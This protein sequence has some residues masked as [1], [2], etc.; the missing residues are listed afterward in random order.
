M[1]DLVVMGIKIG[2]CQ[3][4][5]VD[6]DGNDVAIQAEAFKALPEVSQAPTADVISFHL[7]SGKYKVWNEDGKVIAEDLIFQ[8][9]A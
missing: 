1:H 5:I 3:S 4:W 6:D 8:Q 2:T 9:L 7:I